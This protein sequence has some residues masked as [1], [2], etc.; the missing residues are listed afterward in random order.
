[1]KRFAL[2]GSPVAHSLSPRLFAAAYGG[3]YPYDL[4]ETPFFDDAWARF[5]A[6]YDGI[7]VT[8]PFKVDAFRRVDWVSDEAR[9]CGA[10]NLVVRDGA[11]C[12]GYNTDVDGVTGALQEYFQ[13]LFDSSRGD[14]LV[15]GTGGA[16]RAAV[17]ALHRLG[18]PVTV[19]GRSAE[20][21]QTF[22]ES[23]GCPGVI[24][25]EITDWQPDI[26]IYTLPGHVPVPERLPLTGAIV[27]EAEYRHPS[28]ASSP[29]RAYVGGLRWLLSQAVAGYRLFTGEEPDAAAMEKALL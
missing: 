22:R 8:A 24:L 28:L 4:V 11:L 26:V 17:A 5:L 6:S 9:R 16:A 12:R 23:F 20:K 7:N 18:C 1:M 2:I 27:L 15:V 3:R 21:L 14:A 10:V 19:A 29:C 13:A 25:S